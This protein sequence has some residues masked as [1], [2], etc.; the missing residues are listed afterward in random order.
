MDISIIIINYNNFNLLEQ[1]IKS[2]QKFTRK[3]TYEI[4]IIDNNSTE[5]DV[6]KLLNKYNDIKLIQNKKNVGFAAANN[7]GIKIAKGKYFLLLNNDTEFIEDSISK[8]FDYCENN[9]KKMFIGPELLN[10]DKTH[11]NSIVDF[12]GIANLF[13]AAFFLYLVFPKSKLLNKYHYNYKVTDQPISVDFVAGAFIFG[14][15]EDLKDCNG[16][17]ERFYFYSEEADLCYRFIKN[18]NGKVIYFPSTSIVHIHG[19][20][21]MQIPWFKY[22]NQAKA[23]IQ[24]YQKHFRGLYFFTIMFL[25]YFSLF[26]RVLIYFFGGLIMVN[27]N[28]LVKSYYFLKQ[29]FVYP[30][31]S[32]DNNDT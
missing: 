12:D 6:S 14:K 16:F 7:Q 9:S 26:N 19:A 1:C 15:L 32:F 18:H 8:V 5:G 25:H 2:V 24:F 20:T 3:N 30:R 28:L 27:K 11:Q 31:N 29:L 10:S 13:G 23:K 21:T 4:I 22:F 17:D